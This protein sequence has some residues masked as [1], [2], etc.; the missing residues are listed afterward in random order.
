MRLRTRP[1]LPKAARP[2]AGSRRI[3]SSGLLHM[4]RFAGNRA[5]TVWVQRFGGTKPTVRQGSNGPPV[6]EV[7]SALNQAIGAGLTPDGNFGPLTDGA[8]RAFQGDRGLTI[9]GIVGPATWDAFDPST[10]PTSA[11]GKETDPAND[12]RIRGLPP[13]AAQQTDRIFFDFAETA[14]PAS[15]EPKIA[16]LATRAEPLVLHGSSSEEGAGNVALTSGRINSVS[17]LLA[18]HGHQAAR[19]PNNETAGAVGKIDYRRARVVLVQPAGGPGLNSCAGRSG[20]ETCPTTIDAVFGRVDTLLGAAIDKLAS[21]GSLS[22]AERALVTDLFEEDS[23]SAIAEVGANM[24]DLRSHLATTRQRRQEPSDPQEPATPFH[25]CGN[26]CFSSCGSGALAFNRGNGADSSTTFCAGFTAMTAPAPGTG[27]T[28]DESHEHILIHEGAHGTGSIA[29]QDFA[30]GTQRAF[31]LLSRAEA[32]HNAD[33][34]TALARNLVNP[35][36]AAR[37]PLVVDTGALA[38]IAAIQEPIAWLDRWLEGADLHTADIYRVTLDIEGQPWNNDGSSIEVGMARVAEEFPVTPPPAPP[39]KRDREK[40]AAINDRY[41]RVRKVLGTNTSSL[42]LER[43]AALTWEAGPGRSVTIPDGFEALAM[44]ARIIALLAA[45]LAAF[46]D[47]RGELEGN[48]ARLA[49]RLTDAR[50]PGF[51]FSAP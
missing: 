35:G 42:I 38:G 8:V 40:M 36:S 23:D 17:V 48:Y 44:R 30:K 9:D 29:C 5:S 37:R 41:D 26:E 34:Y 16:A 6:S 28:V 33:S 27:T 39:T 13:D 4:Q 1:A 3:P 49:P 46:P 50:T 25:R 11:P 7:Q 21:P 47:V 18:E 19:T 24:A 51:A 2:A 14:V 43:G 15:E 31:A 10:A 22:Q 12:F 20:A 45:L 32:L